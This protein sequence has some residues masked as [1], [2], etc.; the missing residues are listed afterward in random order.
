MSN[1]LA[2]TATIAF[3]RGVATTCERR[4]CTR[5]ETLHAWLTIGEFGRNGIAVYCAKH[6]EYFENRKTKKTYV[7]EVVGYGGG[8]DE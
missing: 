4:D 6:S 8:G 1:D 7:G 2:Q 3:E 5:D